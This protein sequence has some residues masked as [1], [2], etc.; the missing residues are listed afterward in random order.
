MTA[1]VVLFLMLGLLIGAV[2]A[3]PFA[4]PKDERGSTIKRGWV[5]YISCMG[6]CLG[7][8]AAMG[9]ISSHLR[10]DD[11]YNWFAAGLVISG[12][13]VGIVILKWLRPL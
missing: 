13:L 7:I 6:I 10:L 11:Q 12:F 4:V 1:H 2:A 5:V 9:Q 8:A 3:I